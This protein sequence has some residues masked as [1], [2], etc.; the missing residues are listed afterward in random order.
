MNY[1]SATSNEGFKYCNDKIVPLSLVKVQ[2]FV[3]PYCD[4]C[5]KRFHVFNFSKLLRAIVIYVL[6]CIFRLTR[7]NNFV[8]YFIFVT[9]GIL[10]LA[11]FYVPK[12]NIV[13]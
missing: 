5:S 1:I 9:R 2:K 11:A 4:I 6:I 8:I 13:M 7:L 12:L 10:L 3:F